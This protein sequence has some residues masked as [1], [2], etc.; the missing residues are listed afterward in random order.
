VKVV[1]RGVS[2]NTSP[3]WVWGGMGVG[4]SCG[5]IVCLVTT[6]YTVRLISGLT[7][8]EDRMD[9]PAYQAVDRSLHYLHQSNWV[10]WFFSCISHSTY[11]AYHD[12]SKYHTEQLPDFLEA[13]TKNPL[14]PNFAD[15]TYLAQ[16]PSHGSHSYYDLVTLRANALLKAYHD[17]GWDGFRVEKNKCDMTRFF[18]NN[19]IQIAAV[20]G[21]WSDIDMFLQEAPKYVNSKDGVR[22]AILKAC[23]LTSGNAASTKVLTA[24]DL[25][26]P[27]KRAKLRE[28]MQSKWDFRAVD[29]ERS[30]HAPMDQ[31]TDVIAE[32]GK[33]FMLQRLHP[34][35]NEIKVQTLFGKVY[36]INAEADESV[37]L[38]GGTTFQS[39]PGFKGKFM[40][41]PENNTR[42]DWIIEEGHVPR[43][44]Y[45]AELVAKAIGIDEL[46]VDIFVTKGDPDAAVVNEISISSGLDMGIHFPFYAK[47]WATLVHSAKLTTRQT[48]AGVLEQNIWADQDNQKNGILSIFSAFN[49]NSEKSSGLLPKPEAPSNLGDGPVWS[50]GPD[51]KKL[52]LLDRPC[53]DC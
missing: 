33:G 6:Y 32:T 39:F 44:T 24:E 11:Q 15:P 4:W 14:H 20:L 42:W 28:W 23:H 35:N 43:I 7:N 37:L 22:K 9:N 41:Q 18:V 47:M 45:L 53:V 38:N 17:K 29:W 30:W 49:T 8:D 50:T 48:T 34:F 40:Y 27:E 52:R 5:L 2:P 21:Y 51:A 26:D 10:V 46:R 3:V 16:I 1:N 36:F 19:R 12:A 31:L 25:E 13:V